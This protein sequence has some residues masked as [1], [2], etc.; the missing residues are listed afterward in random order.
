MRPGISGATQHLTGMRKSNFIVA[1]NKDKDAPISEIADVLVVA[2]L[3]PFAG[4]L[5]AKLLAL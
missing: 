3:I 4:A 5:T 2:D 1:I